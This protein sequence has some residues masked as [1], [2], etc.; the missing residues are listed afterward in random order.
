MEFEN[1]NGKRSLEAKQDLKNINDL[2]LGSK[3]LVLEQRWDFWNA[4]EYRMIYSRRVCWTILLMVLTVKYASNL[5]KN[6][7]CNH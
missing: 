4:M 1:A 7:T 2:K 6:M 3:L 5:L